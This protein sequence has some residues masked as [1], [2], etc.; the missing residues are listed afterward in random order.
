MSEYILILLWIGLC[1][2]FAKYVKIKKTELVCG[3]EEERYPW[4]FAFIMFL[5]IIIMAGTRGNFADTIGYREEFLNM[6]YDFPDFEK[7]MEGVKKDKGFSVLTYLLRLVIG[8]SDV[9]Y[10]FV[11]ASI[12]GVI[13]LSVFRKYSAE[14]TVSIFLFVASADYIGW[15]YNGIRQFLAVTIIFAATKLM[16]T[17]RYIPL[18]VIIL[19]ASTIHQSAL[20]M[21]PIVFIAQGKAWNK[22]TLLFIAIILVIVL[23]LDVF[24]NMLDQ[25][26][27]NTQYTNVVRDYKEWNDDGTN[28]LRVLLFSFPTIIA[29]LGRKK[30]KDA[31][32]LINFCVNTSII[33]T[34]LYIISIFTSGLFM[35]RLPIYVSLYGY[36]LLPW[37][38]NHI[39]PKRYKTPFIIIMVG[40]YLLFYYYQM[41]VKWL[42]F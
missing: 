34:G 38:I 4:L 8:N 35:G 2:I 3:I 15:M 41:H 23:S 25:S 30:I 24:T 19:L 33:S 42:L 36:I 26:L 22:K 39:I 17:K 10:F 6:P 5:P 28:P 32:I 7:Y 37:E 31:N 18:L 27:K 40:V 16:I 11:L 14:Y 20:L 9:F 12:Q 13:L 21:I 29:F 1:A